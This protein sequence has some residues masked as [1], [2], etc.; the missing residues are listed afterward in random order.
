MRNFYVT[1]RK[2][3]YRNFTMFLLAF[4][5]IWVKFLISLLQIFD[6][7]GENLWKEKMLKGK[8]KWEQEI[9]D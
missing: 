5:K 7:D 1:K 3:K 9:R 6:I 4:W 2:M 8:W